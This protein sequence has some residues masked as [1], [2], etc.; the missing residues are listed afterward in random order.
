MRTTAPRLHLELM[1]ARVLLPGADVDDRGITRG[2]IGWSVGWAWWGQRPRTRADHAAAR[3]SRDLVG[4]HELEPASSS[5]GGLRRRE[6]VRGVDNLS[7]RGVE[8][9]ACSESRPCRRPGFDKHGR[10]PF[11]TR[12]RPRRRAPSGPGFAG[13]GGVAGPQPSTGSTDDSTSSGPPAQ[14]HVTDVRR[15]WPGCSRGEERRYLVLQAR[16]HRWL[17]SA[18]GR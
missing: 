1:C 7:S 11:D 3:S 13:G 16:M 15:L 12:S 2:W 8:S 4:A 6:R 10:R 17:T 5:E 14:R 18:T 9:S